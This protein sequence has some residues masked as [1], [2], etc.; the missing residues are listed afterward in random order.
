MLSDDLEMSWKPFGLT[1]TYEDFNDLL[2]WYIDEYIVA[3]LNTVED[4]TNAIKLHT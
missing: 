3:P 1:M 2:S 4:N